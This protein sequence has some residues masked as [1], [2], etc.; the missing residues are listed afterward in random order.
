MYVRDD[1][2]MRWRAD[3]D[4]YLK[5]HKIFKRLALDLTGYY[6]IS[7]SVFGK[8]SKEHKK[9]VNQLMGT[10]LTK[11][12][13]A[14]VKLHNNK[15]SEKELFNLYIHHLKRFPK[16]WITIFP[17]MLVPTFVYR[18]IAKIMRKKLPE[19]TTRQAKEGG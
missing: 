12:C 17:Y 6:G 5:I 9:I 15:K 19:S 14:N 13:I 8:Y 16:F 4:E 11:Y 18:I 3:N 1:K 2:M 7:A 10:Y